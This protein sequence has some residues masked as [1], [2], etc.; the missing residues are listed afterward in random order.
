MPSYISNL[1]CDATRIARRGESCSP[2]V[3]TRATDHPPASRCICPIPDRSS[4][5]VSLLTQV[6]LIG[7]F[8]A[9]LTVDSMDT[10]RVQPDRHH[11]PFTRTWSGK[12]SYLTANSVYY[13]AVTNPVN[14]QEEG[15]RGAG[16]K[17]DEG[18][19]TALVK[20]R[21]LLW[22]I[23]G[24]QG[25]APHSLPKGPGGAPRTYR[26]ESSLM[27]ALPKTLWRLSRPGMCMTG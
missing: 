23:T 26:E 18:G 12:Q 13:G 6:H 25:L 8:P 7:R 24:E 4:P 11:T 2:G 3:P 19:N 10:R 21:L 22:G 14:Q 15:R 17:R 9:L 1:G 5:S 20:A 27:I 16:G